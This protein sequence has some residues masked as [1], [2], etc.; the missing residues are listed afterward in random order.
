M[1]DVIVDTPVINSDG[2]E[3]ENFFIGRTGADAPDIDPVV[4]LTG[5]GLSPG[6]FCRAEIVETEDQ[7][8][9]AA[10]L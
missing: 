7:D 8:L 5:T 3:A 9:I 6:E 4:Y 10:V 1:Y 2:T